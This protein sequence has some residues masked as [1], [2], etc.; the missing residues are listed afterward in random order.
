M[1]ERP[2]RNRLAERLAAGGTALAMSARLVRTP[3]IALI[4]KACGFDALYVDLEHSTISLAETGAI[5]VAALGAEVTALVRVPSAAPEHVARVLDAGA[6]GVIVPHV[7]D[8]AQ[9]SR[10][11][12]AARFPPLGGRSVSPTL[13]QLGY[14]PWPA[15]EARRALDDATSVVVMIESGRGVANADAIAAVPGVDILLVGSN[16]LAADLGVKGAA[17]DAAIDDACASVAA[18]CRRHGKV[19]GIGGL[20]GRP[21]RQSEIVRIG[22]RLVMTGHDLGFLSVAASASVEALR[23]RLRSA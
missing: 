2:L 16:D 7:Q 6:M 5:C 13:P 15:A 23:S 18:A 14:R 8:A 22:A 3:E 17:A 1:P 11:V 4:A 9:V 20:A 10:I 19:M 21:D 12:A